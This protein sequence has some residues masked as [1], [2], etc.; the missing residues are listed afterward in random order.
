MVVSEKSKSGEHLLSLMENVDTKAYFLFLKYILNFFNSFN[1]FFQAIET[2]IHLLQPKSLNLLMQI[3]QNFLKPELLK[4]LLTNISFHDEN[5]HKP[6]CDITLGSEG[7]KYLNELQKK[8]YVDVITI[9]RRN[10]LQVYVTA[11]EEIKNRLPVHNVF[12]YKLKVFEAQIALLDSNR[13]TSFN[14]VSF[15]AKTLNGFDEDGLKTEWL[16][17][18]S[19]FSIEEK[20]TLASMNFD[21]MW[22]N[23]LKRQF[24]YNVK[25]PNLKSLLNAIRSLPHSNADSERIFS[26]LTNLKTKNRN[27]LSSTSINAACVFKSA[28]KTRKETS[29][30]MAIGEKHLRFMSPKL[31]YATAAK[32]PKCSITLHAADSDS[33]IPSSSNDTQ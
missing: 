7:D 16:A 33:D 14:D 26:M 30:S 22:K 23:I 24:N 1:A 19:D 32:E 27:R 11:A 8:G 21:D 3:C 17:L 5:N 13:D 2:R 15:I 9:I 18:H 6:L 12:L 10:C 31:L 4:H 20:Q 28:L 25:Y 29:L